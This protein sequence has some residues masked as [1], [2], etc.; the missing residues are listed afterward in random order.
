M[1]VS[2]LIP[3]L[4]F[5]SHFDDSIYFN[6]RGTANGEGNDFIL[7]HPDKVP[8][9]SETICAGSL[10][11]GILDGSLLLPPSGSGTRRWDRSET[12]VL[13]IRC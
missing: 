6:L 13:Q 12:R 3:K 10:F 2:F 11:T 4:K 8:A 5:D 7:S 9:N 1:Q